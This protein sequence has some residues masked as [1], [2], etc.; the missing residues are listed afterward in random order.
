[1]AE[2]DATLRSSKGQYAYR[3][4]LQLSVRVRNRA[5]R[6]LY[7]VTD[8][9]TIMRP[10]L[11]RLELVL[12]LDAP[13]GLT[14]YDFIAPRLRK[15]AKGTGLTLK[16]VVPMPPTEGRINARGKYTEK[17]LP[18]RGDVLV[19]LK[20]GYLERKYQPRGGSLHEFLALQRFSD[21]TSVQVAVKGR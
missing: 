19:S 20:V 4:P 13:S 1:L 5:T 14:Y 12:G 17:E 10:K 11:D 6:A 21:P 7:V 16:F 18:C 9:L 15:V 8:H 2:L 3:K